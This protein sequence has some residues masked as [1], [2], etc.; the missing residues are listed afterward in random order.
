MNNFPPC[1]RHSLKAFIPNL[2]LIISVSSQVL[3]RIQTRFFFNL[4]ISNQ[5]LK[6]KVL[7]YRPETKSENFKKLDSDTMTLICDVKIDILGFLD[8]KHS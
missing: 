8:L 1:N 7:Y 6:C 4:R 5:S 3:T 2:S